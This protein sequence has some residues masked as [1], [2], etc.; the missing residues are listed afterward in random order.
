VADAQPDTQIV[1]YDRGADAPV[2]AC[3][4]IARAL[5]AY[6]TADAVDQVGRDLVEHRVFVSEDRR[7]PASAVAGFAI[8]QRRNAAVAELLWIAVHPALQGQGHGSRLLAAMA[9]RLRAGGAALLEV[10]TL[11]PAAG[12]APYEGTRRFY[13]RHGFIH[14][15]TVQPYP[16]WDPASPCAIYV[17]ILA[18]GA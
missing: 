2:E 5:P 13:E 10:K 15:N 16:G 9:D 14:L 18:A 3:L 7:G 12:Y 1:P 11:G 17:K 4:A 6:F 8:V